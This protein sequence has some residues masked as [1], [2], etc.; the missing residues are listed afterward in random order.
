MKEIPRKI[1]ELRKLL[2]I[3]RETSGF[4]EDPFL[5]AETGARPLDSVSRFFRI[6]P[7]FLIHRP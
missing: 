7:I 1:A 4:S 3:D 5:V 2:E 6:C